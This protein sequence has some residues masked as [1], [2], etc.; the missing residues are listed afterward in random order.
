M[1]GRNDLRERIL[2][3]AAQVLREHGPRPR[4]ITTIAERAQVSRP[5]LYRH[6]RDRTELYDSLM[7]AELQRVVEEVVQ[8]AETS[9]D[10]FQ[11]YV[12]LVVDMVTEAREHPALRA[13]LARHPEILNAQLPR[14][15]PIVLEI[16]EPRL[17]PI[18]RARVASGA[19][20]DVD[21]RTAIT[22]TTRLITSFIT[23][24]LP[25]DATRASL[26]ATVESVLDIAS[27]IARSQ[28]RE[29]K[30]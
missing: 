4:L 9:A 25:E 7:R 6:F 27:T 5:T 13:I 24:P 20:P 8:R 1:A 14:L 29:R 30:A 22:W 11:D 28:V 18:I 21:P 23:M 2:D 19:W 16:A 26:H 12:N 10:P 17:T 15:L 3:A